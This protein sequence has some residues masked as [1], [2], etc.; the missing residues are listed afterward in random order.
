VLSTSNRKR[1]DALRLGA[2]AFEVTSEAGAA[3]KLANRFDLILDTVSAA[4]DFNAALAMLRP[5]GTLVLVGAPPNPAPVSAFALINGN[6]RFVGS[7]IG[8][9][10]ENQELLD[11]CAAHGVL[12]DVEVIPIQQIEGAYERM[13]RGDV[14]YRFV[15]DAESLRR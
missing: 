6:K 4:H 13:L 7:N 3:E 11:Y 2:A 8:S 10:H 15:V 14:R 1:A 5:L 12:A 9:T